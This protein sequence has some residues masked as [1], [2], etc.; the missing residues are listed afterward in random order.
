VVAALA[1]GESVAS[2]HGTIPTGLCSK[3]N[4]ARPRLPDPVPP[5]PT[6]TGHALCVREQEK[7]AEQ[8]WQQIPRS[9]HGSQASGF[10]H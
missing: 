3:I 7:L 5:S 8:I 6:P 1:R 2:H 4:D 10:I 9:R